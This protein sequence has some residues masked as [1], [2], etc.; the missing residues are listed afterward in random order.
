LFCPRE[1]KYRWKPKTWRSSLVH[2]IGIILSNVSSSLPKHFSP[3]TTPST[4]P[5]NQNCLQLDFW[6]S[7]LLEAWKLRTLLLPHLDR[8]LADAHQY[9]LGLSY[10]CP[11]A[12]NS[13]KQ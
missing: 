6:L 7:S 11:I 8:K 3:K 2:S 9:N 1:E 13:K 5:P 4:I 12:A 10:I